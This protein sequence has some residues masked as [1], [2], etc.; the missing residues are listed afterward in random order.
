MLGTT[1]P[2]GSPAHASSGNLTVTVASSDGTTAASATVSVATAQVY[3]LTWSYRTDGNG[4]IDS[5]SVDQGASGQ[6]GLVLTNTGNGADTASFALS[7][8]PA[9]ADLADAGP[10]VLVAGGETTV[11]V[12]LTPAADEELGPNTFQVQ[13]TGGGGAVPSGDLTATVTAKSTG[14][15]GGG[16]ITVEEEDEGW[17]PGFGLLAALSALGAALLLRRRS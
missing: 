9:Y 15:D 7:N 17:L 13:A 5:I 2:A 11:W 12:D 16:T 6:V 1:V 14:G 3:G 4:S 8:A 10:T